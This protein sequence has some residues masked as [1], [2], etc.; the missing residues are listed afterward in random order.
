[1]SH[2]QKNSRG[3]AGDRQEANWNKGYRCPVQIHYILSPKCTLTTSARESSITITMQ[4]LSEFIKAQAKHRV[5]LFSS[6][7]IKLDS[8]F[9]AE[10]L[11]PKAT[12]AWRPLKHLKLRRCNTGDLLLMPSFHWYVWLFSGSEGWVGPLCSLHHTFG[13]MRHTD[14]LV[15]IKIISSERYRQCELIILSWIHW[16]ITF[17]LLLSHLFP[18]AFVESNVVWVFFT[19]CT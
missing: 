7:E 13:P 12:G 4:T 18:F 11:R 8:S 19:F 15:W 17:L 16:R 5:H 9:D 14:S 1:M 3:E 10:K 6:H 2:W